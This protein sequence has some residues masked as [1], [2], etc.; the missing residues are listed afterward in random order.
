MDVTFQ[1]KYQIFMI[2][3]LLNVDIVAPQFG[4][5]MLLHS[6]S[7]LRYLP[8]L[9]ATLDI[10]D[11]HTFRISVL[12]VSIW[13]KNLST[14]SALKSYLIGEKTTLNST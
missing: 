5:S 4:F 2:G 14:S 3:N 9:Q 6:P 1:K 10:H 11:G 8:D 7:A 12:D 13:G